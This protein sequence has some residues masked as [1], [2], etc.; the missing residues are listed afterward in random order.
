MLALIY[1][2]PTMSALPQTISSSLTA[3]YQMIRTRVHELVEP[4]SHEQI[5]RRPYSY[6]NSVGNMLLHLTGN[7]NYYIGAQIAATGYVRHRDREFSDNGM[8]KEELLANFDRAIELV[9]ATIKNQSGEDR[10][11]PYSAVGTQATDRFNMVLTCAGHAYHHIGQII[12]LQKE[13][14]RAGQ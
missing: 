8:A 14:T 10:S 7:L 13:L 4:L 12:Y 1:F 2:S 11:A 6:G 3:Y 9:I 5:W